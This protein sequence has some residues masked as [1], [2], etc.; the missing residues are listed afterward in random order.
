MVVPPFGCGSGA[1][2]TGDARPAPVRRPL[3]RAWRR[4]RRCA[5]G[6]AGWRAAG[7][8]GAAPQASAR[9]RPEL[10]TDDTR[11]R[12]DTRS[13]KPDHHHDELRLGRRDRLADHLR[14]ILL[15]VAAVVTDQAAAGA[16]LAHDGEVGRI[17]ERVL[18][19]VGQPVGH[20]I[21][22]HQHAAAG[23]LGVELP[24]RRRAAG[25]DRALD[26]ARA[27]RIG[28][29]KRIERAAA[30]RRIAEL[31]EHRNRHQRKAADSRHAKPGALCQTAAKTGLLPP[32][33]DRPMVG[34]R[35]PDRGRAAAYRSLTRAK[36]S[37]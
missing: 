6:A 35:R 32:L 20:G 29:E 8:G 9:R 16:V 18:Q 27:A 17:A 1:A 2:M 37:T 13:F 7:A 19:S 5:A 15:F 10:V 25:I 4:A 30:L 21:A 36:L 12:I 3:H 26:R 31:G 23:R 28:T 33:S 34:L 24:R 11:S 22:E 14:P